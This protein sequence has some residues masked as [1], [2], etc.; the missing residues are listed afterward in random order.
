MSEGNRDGEQ[1]RSKFVPVLKVMK[2]TGLSKIQIRNDICRGRF[3][4][5]IRR[6]HTL[7]P[8][9][10]YDQYASGE[11]P[12]QQPRRSFLHHS[13]PEDGKTK[14]RVVSWTDRICR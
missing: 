12:P 14:T 13:R 9:A 1:P 7:I 2:D 11:W 10:L 6:D 4:G 8:R 5:A 3:P